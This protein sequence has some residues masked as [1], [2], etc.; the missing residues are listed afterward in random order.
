MRNKGSDWPEHKISKLKELFFSADQYSHRD[1][2]TQMRDA[3]YS[4]VTRCATLGKSKRLG[5]KRACDLP[6]M[7]PPR[8]PKPKVKRAPRRS[9]Q[10]ITYRRLTNIVEPEAIGPLNDFPDGNK[11]KWIHGDP[12]LGSWSCCGWPQL[13]SSPYCESHSIR[14]GRTYTQRSEIG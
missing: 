1:I 10:T 14:A 9:T 8:E 5:W 12:Q 7:R 6:M 4:D 3:G 2:A 11:C 13:P